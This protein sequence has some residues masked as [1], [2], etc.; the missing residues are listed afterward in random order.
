MPPSA[1]A[2]PPIQTVQR[3]PNFSSKL[4]SGGC[5]AAAAAAGGGDA[6]GTDVG[7]GGSG[8]RGGSAGALTV[9]GGVAAAGAA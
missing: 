1:S 3:V 8:E 7:F 6:A 9:S 5:G 2:T 4:C